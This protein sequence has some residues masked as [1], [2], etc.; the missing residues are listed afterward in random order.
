MTVTTPA[1]HKKYYFTFYT[2]SNQLSKHKEKISNFH[3]N[4]YFLIN[5]AYDEDDEYGKQINLCDYYCKT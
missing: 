5:D 1:C 2:F 4:F 3:C